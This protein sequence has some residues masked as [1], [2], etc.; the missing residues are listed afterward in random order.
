MYSV[1]CT[2]NFFPFVSKSHPITARHW[3][4]TVRT[5]IVNLIYIQL[6]CRGVPYEIRIKPARDKN[7]S[8][9][10]SGN[11]RRSEKFPNRFLL[12]IFALGTWFPEVQPNFKT[13]LHSRDQMAKALTGTTRF[14]LKLFH[15][16]SFSLFTTFT[17][18]RE[19]HTYI[20]RK[21]PGVRISELPYG[22]LTSY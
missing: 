13:I 12:R 11:P 15:A 22:H 5:K 14:N 7:K 2:N 21:N 9:G 6:P 20:H 18:Y 19:G 17:F 3:P 10:Q 16:A 8:A 1:L 4:T